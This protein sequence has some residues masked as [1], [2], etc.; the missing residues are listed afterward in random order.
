MQPLDIPAR[1][2]LPVPRIRRPEQEEFE[3]EYA[4]RSRP[5]VIERG[6]SDWPAIGNWPAERLVRECG[7]RLPLVTRYVGNSTAA[8][9][10]FRM[11]VSDYIPLVC[12]SR[13]E[14]TELGWAG[15]PVGYSLPEL[16]AE[17]RLPYLV[18]SPRS[19]TASFVAGPRPWPYR[20]VSNQFHFHPGLHA[21]AAQVQG[22]KLFRLYHPRETR[23]LGARKPWH[24]MPS[25]G[26]FEIHRYDA[27]RH[28]SLSNA[29]C[30]EVLL[31][32][33]DL[34]FIPAA[35]WHLV[36]NEEFAIVATTFYPAPMTQWRL[37]TTPGVA[38]LFDRVRRW[39]LWMSRRA[40]GHRGLV[41]ASL[42]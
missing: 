8:A 3:H 9:R 42:S 4:R 32:M 31:E 25:R 39:K 13:P 7:N 29:V 27:E 23:H 10:Q 12:G 18:R 16:A 15:E 17:L 20:H 2:I 34:L 22:R 1:E 11:R 36:W 6:A 28:A 26:A 21:F 19:E 33:G 41:P 40:P 37:A 14:A 35:W 38:T 30:H 24:P 5:V